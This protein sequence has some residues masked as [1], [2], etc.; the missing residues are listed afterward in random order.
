MIR[1]FALILMTGVLMLGCSLNEARAVALPDPQQ[2]EQVGDAASGTRSI[3]VAGGCFWGIEA[4]FLHLK[5]VKN[6]VSGYAGGE[7]DTA[8]YEQVSSGKTGHAEA[9]KVTYDPAAIS[10]GQ[11]LKVYFS[12][13]HD[14]T[15]LN[16]QGPDRGTQYRSAIFYETPEQ[17]EVASSYID[18]LVAAKVFD[19][20]IVTRLEPLEKFYVA[21]SYHQNYIAFHPDSLYV[22]I[23]DAPKLVSLKEAFPDLYVK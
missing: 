2:D 21:E 17:K 5:G 4:V 18:Q 23:H 9:V 1:K 14:P 20:P 13:A 10:L 8:T 6:V 3:I 19:K 15:Q 7:E 11:L 16:A 22:M 12:V